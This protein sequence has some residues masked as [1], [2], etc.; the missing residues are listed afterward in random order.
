M[1]KILIAL[2]MI[3][4]MLFATGAPA[5]AT[6][7]PGPSVYSQNYMHPDVR[8]ERFVQYR[9]HHHQKR[10]CYKVFIDGRY[11]FSYCLRWK[12]I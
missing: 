11:D 12:R 3:A 4:G 10:V 2:A 1:R 6:D 8:R 9:Y 5:Q 7:W